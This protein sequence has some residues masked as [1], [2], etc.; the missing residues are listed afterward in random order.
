MAPRRTRRIAF[1]NEK[2]GSCKT[3]LAVNLGAYFA[4]YRQRRVLLVDL[5]S[6]GHVGKSL[7]FDVR[8]V[9]VSTYDLLTDPD[10]TLASAIQ[11]SRIEG[12]DVVCANKSLSDF[13]VRVA[14]DR[15]RERKLRQKLE[16]ATD[17]YDFVIFDTPPSLGLITLN[18]MLTTQEI[19]VPVSLTY[20]A[21]DGC[22][23]ILD[24]VEQVKSEYGRTR[25]GVTLIVPTL[26]RNTNM[27]RDILDKLD[28][29]F[30]R[31]LARNLLGY[32]VKID[33]AQ[34]HG[35]TIWEY[36]P[37]SSGA[38]VLEALALEVERRDPGRPR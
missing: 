5:D 6:Q 8:A 13:T 17:D 4:L 11:P 30:P 36:A 12:L 24:T 9:P 25:L 23:E 1:V 27:A 3:T 16:G 15:D 18:V 7:G 10:A 28:T 29:Y 34:S 33:E 37:S 35:R 20:F 26:Y 22:A 32:N 2:G 14:A 31:Q 21:L 38:R 19:V